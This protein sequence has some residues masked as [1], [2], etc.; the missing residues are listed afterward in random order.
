MP[1]TIIDLRL[2][3]IVYELRL[4]CSKMFEYIKGI[5]YTEKDYTLY[6]VYALSG[7]ITKPGA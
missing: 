1:A 2:T 4:S 6:Y 5:V 7:L 3:K